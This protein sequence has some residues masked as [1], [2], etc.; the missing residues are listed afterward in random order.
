MKLGFC[1]RFLRTYDENY[2]ATTDT[3]VIVP[4]AWIRLIAWPEGQPLLF[5]IFKKLFALVPLSARAFLTVPSPGDCQVFPFAS[6]KSMAAPN[7]PPVG[8]AANAI[9]LITIAP[10]PTLRPAPKMIPRVKS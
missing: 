2:C 6:I 4:S 7:L 9:L 3:H 1:V 10:I 8:P 5:L